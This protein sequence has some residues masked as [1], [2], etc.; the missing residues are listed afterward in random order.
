MARLARSRL[1][2][3]PPLS[4]AKAM[5]PVDLYRAANLLIQQHGAAAKEHAMQRAL[6]L[7]AAGDE[8]GEWTW[9]GVFDA[10]LELQ[11]TKPAEGRATH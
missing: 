3:R 1:Q 2:P 11:S 9:L 4:H 7:R 8:P 6:E 10:V 5:H